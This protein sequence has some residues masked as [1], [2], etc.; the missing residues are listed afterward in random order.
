MGAKKV[1]KWLKREGLLRL[2]NW[3]MHDGL[4]DEQIAH[5]CGVAPKTIYEWKKRYP[6]SI[7]SALKVGRELAIAQVRNK[8]FERAKDGNLAAIIFYL[9]NYDRDNFNDSRLSNEERMLAKQNA[10]KT[11]ADT[12]KVKAETE[13]TKLKAKA[14]KD[15]DKS[16]EEAVN[17]LMDVLEGTVKDEHKSEQSSNS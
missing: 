14:M 12:K 11:I 17:K 8:L 4:T 13:L 16:T 15:G 7:G 6:S 9:K 3:K 2:Q 1:D 10:L 5:N